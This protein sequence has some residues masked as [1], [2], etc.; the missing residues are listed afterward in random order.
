MKR[1]ANFPKGWFDDFYI[2]Q[3]SLDSSG[4]YSNFKRCVGKNLVKSRSSLVP[5]LFGSR[6]T[7]VLN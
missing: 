7:C 6:R 3:L 4:V 5:D 2:F 1:N